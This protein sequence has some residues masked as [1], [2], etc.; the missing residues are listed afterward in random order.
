MIKRF[1]LY[2]MKISNHW[3]F[4]VGADPKRAQMFI[5]DG[6]HDMKQPKR[7]VGYAWL[8]R[9]LGHTIRSY[10]PDAAASQL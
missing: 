7:G 9:W 1:C 5:V 3:R 2:L 6:V 4:F 10:Q 8:N